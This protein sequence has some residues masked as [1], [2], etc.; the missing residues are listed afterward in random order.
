MS[1]EQQGLNLSNWKHR[2]SIVA[3]SFLGKIRRS[4]FRGNWEFSF[5]YIK[6]EV[7]LRYPK[8]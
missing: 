6:F 5:R 8:C 7:L 2:V 4:S 3:V 1:Q